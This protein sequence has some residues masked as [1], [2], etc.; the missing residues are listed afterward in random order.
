[1]LIKLINKASILGIVAGTAFFTSCHNP[2]FDYEGDCSTEYSIGFVYDMNTTWSDAFSSLVWSVNLYAFDSDGLF[3]KE[4]KAKGEELKNP[5]FRFTFGPETL[6]PGHYNFVAWC[7]LDNEGDDENYFSVPEPQKGVTTI[8]ELTCTLETFSNNRY[9]VYSDSRLNFLYNGYIEAELPDTPDGGRHEWII[10]LTQDTNHFNIKL[11]ELSGE[12]IKADDYTV[13]IEC[14]DGKMAYNNTLLPSPVVTYLPWQQLGDEM[15]LGSED[16]TI[17]YNIGL[18]ADLSI[19]RLMA[20][21]KNQTFL[22]VT[23]NKTGDAIIARVPL[24]DYAL[25][26]KQY[27]EEAYRHKMNDQEFLDRQNE[28]QMTFFLYNGKWQ[29]S[30][31]NIESWRIVLHEYGVGD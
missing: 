17:R 1:M 18:S 6:S 11:Q 26:A 4:F 8:E 5:D 25:L 27:Y 31:I 10:Y 12:D 20:D 30:Y 21:Q 15:A 23:S 28:Y 24:I 7:G 2:V 19:S 3:I 16:G 13:I 14:A 22:T 9:P 29:N